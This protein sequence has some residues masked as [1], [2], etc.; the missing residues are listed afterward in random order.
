MTSYFYI[1]VKLGNMFKKE[2]AT[3]KSNQVR[4]CTIITED[5]PKL[6]YKKKRKKKTSEEL[7]NI[8]K[9]VSQI[10]R[11]F[12]I[13]ESESLRQPSLSICHQH[14]PPPWASLTFQMHHSTT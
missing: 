9:M 14:L 6:T 12:L 2:S 4:L 13:H 5:F 10:S 1:W 7:K 8:L 3:G 11:F